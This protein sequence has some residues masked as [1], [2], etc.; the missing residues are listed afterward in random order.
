MKVGQIVEDIDTCRKL[1][2]KL[3][4]YNDPL[5]V[6]DRNITGLMLNRYIKKL[7]DMEVKSDND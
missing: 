6:E 5:T 3:Y 7:E 1:S 2:K 4:D